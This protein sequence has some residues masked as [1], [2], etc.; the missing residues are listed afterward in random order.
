MHIKTCT[1]ITLIGMLIAN[2]C[3]NMTLI[4]MS[5]TYSALW[6]L[7]TFFCFVFM[8]KNN[9]YMLHSIMHN[10]YRVSLI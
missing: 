9:I 8:M 1:T 3:A 4:S 2:I 7:A 5:I 10:F 6:M